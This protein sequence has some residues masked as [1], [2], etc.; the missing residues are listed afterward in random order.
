MTVIPEIHERYGG[1]ITSRGGG[2]VVAH[3][4][5]PARTYRAVRNVVG[6]IEHGFGVVTVRGAWRRETVG[7]SFTNSL[8]DETAGVYGFI[9]AD[10]TIAADA[11]L[12]DSGER[13]LSFVP[14][15]RADKVAERWDGDGVVVDVATRDFTIFGVHGPKATEKVASIFTASAPSERLEIARGAMRDV[16]VTVI[17]DD[18]LSGEV[19]YFV[20]AASD[21]AEQ[22]FDALINY[23][24]NAAPFG[25]ETWNQ[26][27][28]E[29]G[30]P[31]FETELAD[32]E[33]GTVGVRAAYPSGDGPIDSDRKLVGFVAD[34]VPD[35][36]ETIFAEGTPIGR[37]TRAI[38]SPE[39][40]TAIGF[41]VVDSITA[42]A[43]DIGED[44][45]HAHSTT[46]PF[47]EGS[48][49]SARIPDFE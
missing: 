14:A 17:R 19:G 35:A 21:E 2:R 8:P 16:G 33:T 11:Y 7:E 34:A 44:R 20:V 9:E 22:V 48:D 46:L 36:G 39:V 29:A 25:Y 13:L 18:G 10:G 45:I 1:I 47:V 6:A 24:L 26:L 43:M 49:R 40:E 41:G 3:Y 27:T 23:G 32:A 5:R 28:L 15:D 4:G 31:L 38:E 30:T 42:S 12:F 37:V